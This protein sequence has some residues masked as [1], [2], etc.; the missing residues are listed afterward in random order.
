VPRSRATL[1]R[2]KIP[3]MVNTSERPTEAFN[4][5]VPGFWEGDLI[6]G[7]S[8]KSQIATLV[9][10]TTRFTMLVP[11]PCDRC[12]ERVAA[13]LATLHGAPSTAQ[14]ETPFPCP[15]DGR[16]QVKPRSYTTR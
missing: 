15:G 2:G 14:R 12:A 9:E 6:I 13:L 7:K 11:I 5:A 10:R 3:D 4:R 8:D 1:N 16:T